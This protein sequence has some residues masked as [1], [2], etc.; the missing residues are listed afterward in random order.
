[1]TNQP[2]TILFLCK[3]PRKAIQEVNK[4]KKTEGAAEPKDLFGDAQRKE[5]KEEIRREEGGRKTKVRSLADILA[6]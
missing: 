2:T 4:P 6:K 5:I 1:M 3:Q